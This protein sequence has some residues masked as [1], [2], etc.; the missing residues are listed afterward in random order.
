MP[1]SKRVRVFIV[2]VPALNYGQAAHTVTARFTTQSQYICYISST[3]NLDLVRW[4][5][6]QELI[7][8]LLQR[9]QSIDLGQGLELADLDLTR[10]SCMLLSTQQRS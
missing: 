7:E 3:T 5:G 8:L 10:R 6:E 9:L 4:R 1:C 2:T